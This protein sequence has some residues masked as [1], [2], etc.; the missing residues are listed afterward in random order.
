MTFKKSMYTRRS[1]TVLKVAESFNPPP[2]GFIKVQ[3]RRYI[4]QEG[5]LYLFVPSKQSIGC[6]CFQDEEAIT[7]SVQLPYYACHGVFLDRANYRM[8]F[9]EI[10]CEQFISSPHEWPSSTRSVFAQ[11]SSVSAS[12][13]CSVCEIRPDKNVNKSQALSHGLLVRFPYRGNGM[14]PP[15]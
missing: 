8:V 5:R 10:C 12:K 11:K 4:T 14:A 1:R 13:N 7:N 3:G 2:S 15:P 6:E 9:V